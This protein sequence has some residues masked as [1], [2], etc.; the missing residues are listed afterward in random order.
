M[1]QQL[2]GMMHNASVEHQ[3][4]DRSVLFDNQF[5]VC[6]SPYDN[7]YNSVN[8]GHNIDV[9]SEPTGNWALYNSSSYDM[10]LIGKHFPKVLSDDA[11]NGDMTNLQVVNGRKGI[12]VVCNGATTNKTSGYD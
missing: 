5:G 3:Q 11:K 1:R 10:R 4:T 8:H 2:E 9:V 12:M 6:D 7:S